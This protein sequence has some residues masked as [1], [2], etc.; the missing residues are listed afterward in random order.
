MRLSTPPLIYSIRSSI[1]LPR[2]RLVAHPV[3]YPCKIYAGH[4]PYRPFGENQ[5]SPGSFSILPLSTSHP[6][7]L[8]LRPVRASS[9]FSSGFTLLMDR[10]PGFGYYAQCSGAICTH[11]FGIRFRF[12]CIQMDLDLRMNVDSPAHS[13]IGTRSLALWARISN[14]KFQLT[15]KLQ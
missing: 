11:P 7:E 15:N 5:L 6:T 9:R 13:S 14:L 10:S 1:E 2:L 12:A 3:L 8:Q 4:G